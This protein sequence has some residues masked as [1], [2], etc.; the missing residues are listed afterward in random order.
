MR[1]Y[2]SIPDFST[3]HGLFRALGQ[4]QTAWCLLV[5]M[6]GSPSM[7]CLGTEGLAQHRGVPGSLAL[8]S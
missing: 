6:A 4:E 8:P 1:V 3:Q 7:L 2:E 5:E